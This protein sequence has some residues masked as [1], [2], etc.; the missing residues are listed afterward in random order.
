MSGDRLLSGFGT[1]LMVSL[2]TF[3]LRL[4]ATVAVPSFSSA[5]LFTAAKFAAGESS[6]SMMNV[7]LPTVGEMPTFSL[8]SNIV[9][10]KLTIEI[11]MASS[12]S[13]I[14]LR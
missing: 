6:S 1:G 8:S 4:T 9:V 11:I 2:M 12:F 14:L 7:T 3:S 13:I 5:L 10:P